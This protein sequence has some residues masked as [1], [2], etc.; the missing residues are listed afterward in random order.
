MQTYNF[1]LYQRGDSLTLIDAGIDTEKCWNAFN[2]VMHEN[3][4]SVDDLTQIILTHNHFDHIGLVNRISSMK[5]LPVFA[6][7]KAI[8]RLKRDPDYF[9]MRVEFFDKLFQEM[10]CDDHGK[11]H[12]E[13]LKKSNQ[14]NKNK[15]IETDITP[16]PANNVMSGLQIIETPGHSAD[17]VVLYDQDKKIL[18]GGDFLVQHTSSAAIIDPDR[19][20]NRILSTV[21][22]INS[23]RKCLNLDVNVVYSGHGEKINQFKDLTNNRLQRFLHKSQKILELIQKGN[24][25]ANQMA[26]AYYKER[27]EQLFPLVISEIIGQ[28]DYLLLEKK[29]TKEFKNGIWHH[30]AQ[31]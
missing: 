29:I 25:T 12:V 22:Y 19:E 14:R 21:E 2:N 30:Y 17:H 8:Y 24:T 4:F 5:D 10:D 20:G 16:F 26:L 9:Q 27:Y 3:G 28:L 11:K 31:N 7:N 18:F 13:K 6:H 23:L 15:I 1:Y